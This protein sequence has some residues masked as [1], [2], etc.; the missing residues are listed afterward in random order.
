MARQKL[1]LNPPSPPPPPLP[2]SSAP[3]PK[4]A[5][6]SYSLDKAFHLPDFQ[7]KSY[8]FQSSEIHRAVF[9]I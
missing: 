3:R 1:M 6:F 8:F 9:Y 5:Y 2:T 4:Q 7:E